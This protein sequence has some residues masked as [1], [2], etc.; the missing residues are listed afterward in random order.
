MIHVQKIVAKAEAKYERFLGINTYSVILRV[1]SKINLF[2]TK[3]T[4]SWQIKI[5]FNRYIFVIY[6]GYEFEVNIYLSLVD[7]ILV[8]GREM[9]NTHS[10]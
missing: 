5:L 1:C 3:N 4:S 9:I 2:R 6:S 7:A 10:L 8:R